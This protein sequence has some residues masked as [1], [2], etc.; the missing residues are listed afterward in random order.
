MYGDGRDS[1]VKKFNL[2]VVPPS[3]CQ[4]RLRKTI[5]GRGFLLDKPSF[6]C[7]KGIP[8]RKKCVVWR[9]NFS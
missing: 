4:D 5:L 8:D 2:P 6:I 3:S 7:A 1:E 9:L